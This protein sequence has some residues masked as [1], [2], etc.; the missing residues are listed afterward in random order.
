MLLLLFYCTSETWQHRSLVVL[1]LVPACLQLDLV[2]VY[3]VLQCALAVPVAQF[4][5]THCS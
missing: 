1:Q 2:C 4:K 5:W 3:E